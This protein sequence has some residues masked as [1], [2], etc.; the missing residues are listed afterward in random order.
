MY[1]LYTIFIYL[2]IDNIH[3]DLIYLLY[4]FFGNI[5]ILVEKNSNIEIE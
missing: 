2:S 4:I 3:K 5:K 1:L